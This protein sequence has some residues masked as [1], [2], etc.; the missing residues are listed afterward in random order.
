MNNS[1]KSEKLFLPCRI[2]FKFE[3][4]T[5]WQRSL[6]LSSEI[7]DLAKVFPS[8]EQFNLCH[9][10]RKAADSINLNI[11]EGCTGQTNT[12]FARFLGY[13]IRSCVE[14][15]SCLFLAR[16]KQSIDQDRFSYF[17]SQIESL[18]R[19]ITKLRDTLK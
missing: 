15:I 8:Y 10:I 7:N 14:V 12:E 2:A 1:C 3:S 19:M 18:V 11:A 17:Y 16:K 13:S 5:V 4:L 9:Q 6:E